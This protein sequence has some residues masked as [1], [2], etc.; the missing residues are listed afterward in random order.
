MS[1]LARPADDRALGYPDPATVV[2]SPA[3]VSLAFKDAYRMLDWR[4]AVFAALRI[5]S[6][7][8]LTLQAKLKEIG[9]M[10]GAT[11]PAR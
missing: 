2:G 10:Q 8:R 1:L 3:E 9:R 5:A 6:L 11:A 4:I 7:D